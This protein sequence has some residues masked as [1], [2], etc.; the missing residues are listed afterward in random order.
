MHSFTRVAIGN[1]I[2]A[3]EGAPPRGTSPTGPR[4]RPPA[5]GTPCALPLPEVWPVFRRTRLPIRRALAHAR[6]LEA[7]TA[8]PRE[9]LHTLSAIPRTDPPPL[10]VPPSPNSRPGNTSG[11]P[12]TPPPERRAQAADR[13]TIVT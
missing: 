3:A 10:R 6:A 13:P 1:A 12:T 5:T 7:C 11:N 8:T 9:P 4:H 2:A